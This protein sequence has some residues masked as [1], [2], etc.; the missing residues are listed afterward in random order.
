MARKQKKRKWYGS[1]WI[2]VDLR[3]AIYKRHGM[4]CVWCG[5]PNSAESIDHLIP[6][7]R[8]SKRPHLLVAACLSCNSS[9][10]NR[11]VKAYLQGRL[12]CEAILQRLDLRLA[13]ISR[14]EALQFRDYYMS[15]AS[16]DATIDYTPVNNDD[17]PF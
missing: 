7:D 12:D 11:P 3:W 4:M 15:P 17:I 5:K 10:G 13:P 1:K 8:S 9:R 16:F 2:R 6:G 14:K